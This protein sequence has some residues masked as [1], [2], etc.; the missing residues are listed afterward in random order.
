LAVGDK[1]RFFFQKKK[2]KYK[3]K[4]V[5]RSC[6]FGTPTL[7]LLTFGEAGFIYAII[8]CE[9]IPCI[10]IAVIYCGPG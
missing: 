5:W 1:N 9:E 8:I 7:L 3:R 10:S 2:K 4:R 6:M